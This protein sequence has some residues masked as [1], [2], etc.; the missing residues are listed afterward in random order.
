MDNSIFWPDWARGDSWRDFAR[1]LTL[2]RYL[3]NDPEGTI[4]YHQRLH[5]LDARLCRWQERKYG[6]P[7]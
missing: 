3:R 1:A 4:A 6:R 2:R 7:A 5:D